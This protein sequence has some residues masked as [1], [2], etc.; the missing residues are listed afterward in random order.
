M[1]S[2]S[3]TPPSRAR[4]TA[5]EYDQG[6]FVREQGDGAADF[7]PIAHLYK[8][9]QVYASPN[10]AHLGV[11]EE[12]RSSSPGPT[13]TY[14]M[15][16]NVQEEFLLRNLPYDKMDLCLFERTITRSPPRRGRAGRW[17]SRPSKSPASSVTSRRSEGLHAISTSGRSIFVE[18]VGDR[19]LH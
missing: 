11:P 17:G 2:A 12:I 15:E 7:K 16:P 1:P 5:L 19:N 14:S 10:A 3:A 6:F 13:D 8:T 9:T 4:R 18:P